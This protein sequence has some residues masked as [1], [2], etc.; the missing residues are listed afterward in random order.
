MTRR[1]DTVLRLPYGGNGEAVGVARRVA[2]G[3]FVLRGRGDGPEHGWST[4]VCGTRAEP[5]EHPWNRYRTRAF[6]IAQ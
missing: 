2:R 3:L 5:P 6:C 4:R 1:I